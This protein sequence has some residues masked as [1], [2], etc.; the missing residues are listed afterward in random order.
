LNLAIVGPKA[1]KLPL[2]TDYVKV[3]VTAPCP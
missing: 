1:N 3:I 2:H